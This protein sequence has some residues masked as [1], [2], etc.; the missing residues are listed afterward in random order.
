MMGMFSLTVLLFIQKVI[1]GCPEYN[2][3]F[4]SLEPLADAYLFCTCLFL[5]EV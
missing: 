5:V 3:F 4:S 1:L 2:L